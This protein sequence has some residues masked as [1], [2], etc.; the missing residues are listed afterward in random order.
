MSNQQSKR[1]INIS[2]ELTS[3]ADQWPSYDSTWHDAVSSKIFLI[4][5]DGYMEPACITN[6]GA[7][8]D[9]CNDDITKYIKAD[10]NRYEWCIDTKGEL[11]LFS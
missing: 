11:T 2:M 9:S 4:E 10:P 7:I 1:V 8:I 3:F 5:D 6:T